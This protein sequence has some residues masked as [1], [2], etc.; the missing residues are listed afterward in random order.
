[1]FHR[2]LTGPM[3][4]GDVVVCGRNRKDG[5][6]ESGLFRKYS[7]QNSFSTSDSVSFV[8]DRNDRKVDCAERIPTTD[9]FPLLWFCFQNIIKKV[10]GQKFVYK[11]VSQPDPSVAEGARSDEE[12]LRREGANP[13]SQSKSQGA[14]TSACPTKSLAQVGYFSRFIVAERDRMNLL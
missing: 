12:V 1:M 7:L 2:N 14:L 5:R 10:S 9:G 4:A 11:F 6:D 13:N 8:P 3:S